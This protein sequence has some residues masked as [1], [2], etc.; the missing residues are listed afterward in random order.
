MALR[1]PKTFTV[2][3]PDD[4]LVAGTKVR[5]SAERLDAD[6]RFRLRFDDELLRMGFADAKGASRCAT[7]PIR[8]SSDSSRTW[9]SR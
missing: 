8:G 7:L 6:E 2:T 9:G 4:V 5:V 1:A 3:A